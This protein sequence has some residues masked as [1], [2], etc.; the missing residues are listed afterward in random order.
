MS[1]ILIDAIESKAKFRNEGA[2][3]DVRVSCTFIRPSA[4]ST[5]YNGSTDDSYSSIALDSTT[6]RC[7]GFNVR[8]YDL[9]SDTSLAEEIVRQAR[10]CGQLGSEEVAVDYFEDAGDA[11]A[12]VHE[13]FIQFMRYRVEN[14][15]LKGEPTPMPPLCE[16]VRTFMTYEEIRG[17]TVSGDNEPAAQGLVDKYG[18]LLTRYKSIELIQYVAEYKDVAGMTP[19]DLLLYLVWNQGWEAAERHFMEIEGVE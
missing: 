10:I 6:S 3:F 12:A 1:Q 2:S 16:F 18:F 8:P 15:K 14:D 11:I 7:F 19:N 17:M 13:Q 9:F 4:T 5:G